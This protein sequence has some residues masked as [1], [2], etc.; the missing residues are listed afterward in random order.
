MNEIAH[1]STLG[2][3]DA[4]DFDAVEAMEAAA[5]AVGWSIE[6]RQ[7]QA[8]PLSASVAVHE[9]PGGVVAREVF[10]R[11]LEVVGETPP[12]EVTIHAVLDGQMVVNGMDVS[13]RQVVV[14]PPRS[15]LDLLSSDPVDAIT[16]HVSER[17]F[18][19]YLEPPARY[20]RARTRPVESVEVAGDWATRLA[21]QTVSPRGV[22][23]VGLT[24]EVVEATRAGRSKNGGRI[25]NRA[26]LRKALQYIDVHLADPIHVPELAR[27][28]GVGVRRLQR[29]FG[30]E[31]QTTPSDYVRTRRL[32]NARRDLRDPLLEHE[33]IATIAVLNGFSHPGRF[34]AD[35]RSRYGET[36]REARRRCR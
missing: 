10:N 6:Y 8:G 11:R 7:L 25:D 19:A 5:A 30:R 15:E 3:V 29:V 36:P 35:F 18:D 20:W 12:G 34:A 14:V 4:T 33:T 26:A 28:A 21:S 2:Y 1:Q 9:R 32:E 17:H 27:Q 22:G 16:L 13:E 23:V 24:S 31:L